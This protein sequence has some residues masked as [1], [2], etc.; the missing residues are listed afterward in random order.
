MNRAAWSAAIPAGGHARPGGAGKAPDILIVTSGAERY[1][2]VGAAPFLKRLA[3]LGA[4]VDAVIP[5]DGRGLH[6][7][8]AAWSRRARARAT[9]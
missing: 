1:R 5:R 3:A 9:A 6:P 4:G 7:L 8:C 2:D